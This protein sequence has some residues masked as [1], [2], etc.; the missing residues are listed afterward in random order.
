MANKR[1]KAALERV[2][3]GK[4]YEMGDAVELL[5]S[6]P[7]PKFDESV[8]VALNLG[9]DPR[10][11]EQMVRGA[12]VLPHGTGS[13]TRVLVFARGEKEAEARE[14]AEV[15]WYEEVLTEVSDAATIGI[16]REILDSERNH[17][18]ALGGK[19]MPASAR[20]PETDT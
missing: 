4:L 8:D 7:A 2:D 12:I 5:K 6:L 20:T 15:A 16:L 13:E 19:W 10:H 3:R 17:L 18:D 9:V 11:A 14:A 1:F